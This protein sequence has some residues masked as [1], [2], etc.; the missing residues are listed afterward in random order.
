MPFNA[1][2]RDVVEPMAEPRAG[3]HRRAA[4]WCTASRIVAISSVKNEIDIIEPFVGHALA[5]ADHI[6]VADGDTDGTLEILRAL[7]HEGLPL[8]VVEDPTAG[9]DAGPYRLRRPPSCPRWRRPPRPS[10]SDCGG[11]R[12]R[13]LCHQ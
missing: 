2:I 13:R 7:Q 1:R 6:V 3:R 11:S 10:D 8:T 9:K 4:R 12:G 5:H